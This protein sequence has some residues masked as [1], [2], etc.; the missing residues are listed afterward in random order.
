MG[1]TN[2]QK[3]KTHNFSFKTTCFLGGCSKRKII[4]RQYYFDSQDRMVARILQSKM[5]A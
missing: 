3:I 1:I 5:P 4:D 2:N